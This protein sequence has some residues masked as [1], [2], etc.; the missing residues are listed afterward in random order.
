ML[1]CMCNPSTKK[2]EAGGLW[3]QGQPGLHNDSLSQKKK[4]ADP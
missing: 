4:E 2:A 1:V 3:V